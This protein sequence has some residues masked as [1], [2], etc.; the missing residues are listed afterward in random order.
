MN[1]LQIIQLILSLAPGGITITKDILA[2]IQEIETLIGSLPTEH[3]TATA[4]VIAKALVTP[5]TPG[6][7]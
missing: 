3:Q 7:K 5:T 4:T 6:S 2:L 1:I